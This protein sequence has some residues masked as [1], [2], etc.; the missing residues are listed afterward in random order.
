M[1]HV[2]ISYVRENADQVDRLAEAF[3][4]AGVDAWLDR[5]KIKPG[6]RWR[7]VIRS[8]IREGEFFIAC[9]SRESAARDRTHMNEDLLYAIEEL[10]LRPSERA[11][12]LPVLLGGGKVP[13]TSIGGGET[14]ADL[15]HV[16]LATDWNAGVERLIS[17]VLESRATTQAFDMHPT[18][19]EHELNSQYRVEVV[20]VEHTAQEDE[21]S[22]PEPL[23]IAK[24]L[25]NFGFKAQLGGWDSSRFLVKFATENRSS[26]Y[27]IHR[28]NSEL[29]DRLVRALSE[30]EIAPRVSVLSSKEAAAASEKIDEEDIIVNVDA[31][32]AY[33]AAG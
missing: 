9:F 31:L 10:R 21:L 4:N 28:S 2:F 5:D 20:E 13:E 15:Q 33:R 12:F 14:L 16:N 17:T 32:V 11:W 30:L 26:L 1:Q 3:R 7:A 24:R 27:V 19:V 6:Q 29:A 23:V 25:S 8:A 18:K 22:N